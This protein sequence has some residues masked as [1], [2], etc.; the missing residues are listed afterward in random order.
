MNLNKNIDSENNPV[1]ILVVEDSPTQAEMLKYILGKNG[2]RTIIAKNGE[3]A[4]NYLLEHLPSVVISDIVMPGMD[5]YELCRKIKSDI[6]TRNIPVILLTSLSKS[7]DL[8]KAVECG[9]DKFVSKPYNE[10]YLLSQIDNILS[11]NTTCKR[12]Q[13]KETIEILIRN[14]SYFINAD[15]KQMFMLLISTYEAAV[16]KNEELIQTQIDLLKQKEFLEETVFERTKD[17]NKELNEKIEI[18]K[19]LGIK[20][21]IEIANVAALKVEIEQRKLAEMK[22]NDTLS[23]LQHTNLELEEA[24]LIVEHAKKQLEKS[25]KL[26]DIFLANMSHEI[27]TPMNAIIGFSDL[28][29]TTSLGQKE[30]EYVKTI[31]ISGENL[32]AII[33]DILDISKIEAG[34]MTF[35]EDHFSVK[36]IIKSLKTMMIGKANE[37]N[38]ELF[39]VCDEDVPNALLGDPNRLIQI[40]IN[41]VGN[42]IKFTQKGMITVHARVCQLNDENALI[43]FSVKDTGIGIN[44]S[45]LEHIFE[46]FRQAE[47]STTRK[48]GGTGLGLSIVK[49]LVELQGGTLSVK[50]EHNAGSVFSFRIRYKNSSQVLVEVA[51]QMVEK[52]SI[53]E[54]LRKLSILMV[55]DHPMNIML[56]SSLF[57]E[58][59]LKFHNAENGRICIDKLKENNFDIILMDME[60]PVM[61]GYEATSIIRNELKSN[62]PIIAMTAHAKAGEREKCIRLGMNDYLSKPIDANLLFEKMYHLTL[63]S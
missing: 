16:Q 10:N 29:S 51:P 33:N 46:R 27:R 60:M 28:L 22:L 44:Q 15:L 53:I 38:I 37:K 25:T 54:N 4:F 24:S 30:L 13:V 8:I 42:A 19:E 32:L 50:S 36:E 14:K 1:E 3:D 55:E 11:N 58:N 26:K 18:E 56:I 39:F 34:M 21:E 6:R 49:Q 63:N 9:S 7:E 12:K 52:G 2:Y 23:L 5:G 20:A 43:E 40:L 48:Y 62:I 41:L 31:N 35:E 47:S 45:E 57:S 59:N 61:N 17:L